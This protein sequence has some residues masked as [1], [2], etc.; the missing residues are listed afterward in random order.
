MNKGR[1]IKNISN[2]YTVLSNDKLYICKA[3]G[4]FRN[5][6]ITPLVGDIVEFDRN[7]NYILD[8]LPRA[9]ELKRPSISNIDIALIIA[10]LKKPDLSLNLLDKELTSIILAKIE[11]VICFTKLDLARKEELQELNKIKAYYENI[12]IKVFTNE[13]LNKLTTYLKD[14]Y[15]VLT[16]QSGAGKSSFLNK[17]D[18]SLN[19]KEGEISNALNRGK[20]TTRHTEFYQIKGI[21]IADT[22]GFS[23]LD[24]STYSNMDIKDTFLEFKNYPCEFKDCMHI[25]EENCEIKR[26][27]QESKIL[28]SRYDNYCS[29]IK[30]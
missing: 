10:S 26:M 29:F 30:R 24:L 2:D 4:K 17:L 25:K 15:V 14:K 11:P 16:G 28:Q 3:R 27:V 8:I 12:G 19:L 9:N 1:I 6:K 13:E 23:S 20:H 22:P 21:F 7:N 5:N 18:L